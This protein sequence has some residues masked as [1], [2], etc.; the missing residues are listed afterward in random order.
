MGARKPSQNPVETPWKPRRNHA[1]NPYL[2]FGPSWTP[3]LEARWPPRPQVGAKMALMLAYL[4]SCWPI[5]SASCQ[6]DASR[7]SQMPQHS[8]K[9][10]QHS[11]KMPQHS[12]TWRQHSPNMPQHSPNIAPTF[13][14]IAPTQASRTSEIIEKPLVFYNVFSTSAFCCIK[15]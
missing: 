7:Y 6:Q 15:T 11:P 10:P 4:G 5:L 1:E 2:T 13:L 3:K 12:P 14:N 8:P 9:M